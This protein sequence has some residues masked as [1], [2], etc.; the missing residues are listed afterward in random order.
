MSKAAFIILAA[1]DTPE[2]L[3]R[4]VNAFMGALEYTR[5]GG[6]EARIIF[7]GAGTQ[8]AAA[9]AEKAHKYNDL[10]QKVRGQIE[11]ACSYCAGAF[12]VTAKMKESNIALIDEFK[13]HPSFKKLIDDGYQVLIF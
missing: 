11:G 4:V 3:G 1:G 13:G 5:E 9:F 7:D 2:S 12:E 10:F 8:A 6:G